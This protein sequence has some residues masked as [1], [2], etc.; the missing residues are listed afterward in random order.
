MSRLRFHIIG[1]L[2]IGLVGVV[3]TGTSRPKQGAHSAVRSFAE[4]VG[5]ERPGDSPRHALKAQAPRLLSIAPQ[6]D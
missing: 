3:T 5:R 1:V 2:M 6:Q 4:Q